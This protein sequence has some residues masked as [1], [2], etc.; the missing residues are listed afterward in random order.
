ME[1]MIGQLTD[2]GHASTP[3]GT[4]GNR[5]QHCCAPNENWPQASTSS[6]WLPERIVGVIKHAYLRH[7]TYIGGWSRMA[8]AADG[9][10]AALHGGE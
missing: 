4:G 5:S 3:V 1:E 2:D 9:Y 8:Y 7:V 10:P 6:S